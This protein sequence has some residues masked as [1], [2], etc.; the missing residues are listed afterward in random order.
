MAYY[1]GDGLLRNA[2]VGNRAMW[3]L[4]LVIVAAT[5]ATGPDGSSHGAIGVFNIGLV[6]HSDFVDVRVYNLL[7]N[8]DCDFD[9]HQV[10]TCQQVCANPT[11]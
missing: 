9:K 11:C 7:V 1:F 3:L 5:C 6:R 10:S 2:C 4:H 8:C